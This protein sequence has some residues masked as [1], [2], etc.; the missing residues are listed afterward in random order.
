MIF[1]ICPFLSRLSQESLT[2]NVEFEVFPSVFTA[3][4]YHN[5]K[6]LESFLICQSWNWKC[7]LLY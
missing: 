1:K 5:S 2:T 4:D 7:N 3:F 6:G